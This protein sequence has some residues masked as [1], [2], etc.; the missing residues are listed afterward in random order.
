MAKRRWKRFYYPRLQ[1]AKRFVYTLIYRLT[2]ALHPLVE[3][4]VVIATNRSGELAGNLRYIYD[5][6]SSQGHPA[7]IY[8]FRGKQD[9]AFV[10][11]KRNVRFMRAMACAE[12]TLIDDFFPLVY[13]LQIRDGAHLVQVWHALGA[14]KRV[15]YSRLGK[16]GGPVETS[17]SH[18]NY[19]DAIVSA[20]AIRHNYAEAFGI[21][22]NR[23]Y[24]TGV[25]R[26]D[27]FFD[28]ECKAAII[29]D[30]YRDLPI[31]KNKRVLLFAPTFRGKGKNTAHYPEEYLDLERLGQRL[32][33]GELFILKMHPFIKK[34]MPIPAQYADRMIDLT[35]FP[36][37]NHLL[38][39][40]D[41]LITD[42]S[43]VIFEYALLKRPLIFYAPDLAQYQEDRDFYY[44]FEEYRF[45]PFCADF[46]EL[47]NALG[48]TALDEDRYRTFYEKFLNRCDGHATERFIA[49]IFQHLPAEGNAASANNEV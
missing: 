29:N 9:A 27:L 43:S 32:A 1:R 41:L 37:I 48:E 46:E 10:R 3:N 12:Y 4:R 30:L 16:R 35:G 34:P 33:A 42:Y 14:F 22:V 5:A 47:L 45:G 38:L 25:P 11:L 28:E 49:T 8:F 39:V 7:D 20:D 18:K 44:D 31:L 2:A 15:G 19:T 23:V 26:S 21:D 36:E 13:P 6:L 40:T 17:I 24:A